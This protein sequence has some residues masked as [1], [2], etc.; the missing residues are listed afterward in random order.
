[1]KCRLWKGPY[2]EAVIDL[3]EPPPLAMVF[4]VPGPGTGKPEQVVYQ[5]AL[6]GDTDAYIRELDNNAAN[7]LWAGSRDEDEGEADLDDKIKR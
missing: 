5:R 1:M 6:P 7:Y 3:P 2:D 4:V